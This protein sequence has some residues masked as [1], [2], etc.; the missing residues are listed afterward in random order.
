LVIKKIFVAVMIQGSFSSFA[1]AHF[2][3]TKYDNN[4][5]CFVPSFFLDITL[6][7]LEGGIELYDKK[8]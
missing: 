3:F 5:G 6:S 8:I 7:D 2:E 4:T 1:I